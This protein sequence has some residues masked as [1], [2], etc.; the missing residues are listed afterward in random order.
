MKTN[1]PLNNDIGIWMCCASQTIQN[2]TQKDAKHSQMPSLHFS[3]KL[4]WTKAFDWEQTYDHSSDLAA[5]SHSLTAALLRLSPMSVCSSSD[6]FWLF[7]V[8]QE[9]KGWMWVG[10]CE[11]DL[12]WQ[13]FRGQAVV[14][15]VLLRCGR[16]HV[17]HWCDLPQ[18]QLGLL[19]AQ[20]PRKKMKKASGNL[21]NYE[22]QE[23]HCNK[24]DAWATS[25]LGELGC[26]IFAQLSA[27]W[28]RA[29]FTA[30]ATLC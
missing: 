20:D 26:N 14:C 27:G 15:C 24:T 28:G 21:M 9:L 30:T 17:R 13:G 8:H 25:R 3:Q 18:R 5:L 6:I 12:V 7:Q 1:N 10:L 11:K 19:H 23:Q 16:E 29:S 2:Q 22:Q 4:Q